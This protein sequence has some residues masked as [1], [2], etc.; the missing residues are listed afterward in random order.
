MND[1]SEVFP[2]TLENTSFLYTI[3]INL[4]SSSKCGS[5]FLKTQSK[6]L[7]NVHPVAFRFLDTHHCQIVQCTS[8][9]F[10]N[11]ELIVVKHSMGEEADCLEKHMYSAKSSVYPL[12]RQEIHR[13]P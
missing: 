1:S 13:N 9:G 5:L 11:Y 8:I 2:D 3:K 6:I 7:H 12:D 10:P 4:R